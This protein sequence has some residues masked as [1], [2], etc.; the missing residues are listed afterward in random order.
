M[1]VLLEGRS[2]RPF[3]SSEEYLI[4]MKE[5]LAEW[6]NA[7]YPELRINLDN[8]MDRLDTGV[9]LCKHA[10]NVRKYAG[11][12]VARRQ[13]RKMPM[14]RSITS[15][16]LPMSQVGDMPYLPNA[17]AGTFF[18]RDNVSNFIDWCRNS[19]GIIECLLFETE[20]LIMRKNERHVILCLLEVARRGAKFGMLAPLLVQMERQIDR[21]IAA[22]NK[23]ANG[24]DNEESDDEYEEEPCL[25]YGPQPQIVT[26][27]L[28]TLHELV[29]DIVEECTCPTQ[30]PMIHVAEGKY[31]IGDTKV[32][33]YV[34]VLRSHVM[35][36][37]GGGW[38]T[39]SHYLEKHDP[40]RCRNSHR[41][42]VSAKLIQKA[43]GSFDLGN[44]Q[45]HYERS[46]PPR[47]RR[48]SASS[49]GS[50]QNLQSAQLHAP[51]RSISSNRS[52]SPTPHR[53]TAGSKQ[54]QQHQLQSS[55]ELKK[56]SR[57][58]TPH[59]KLLASPNQHQADLAKQ[60]SRSPTPRANL[61]SRSPTPRKNI[62]SFKRNANEEARSPPYHGKLQENGRES[63][64]KVPG[65]FTKRYIVEG[66]VARRAV[67]KD[68]T[69]KYEPSIYNYKC[70]EDSSGSRSPTPSKEEQPPIETF[71]KDTT[72]NTQKSPHG[73]GEH[74]DNCSEVSDEGYRSLGALQSST[75]N[76]NSASTQSSPT[77]ADCQKQP[78]KTES[79]EK[80][81]V[82]TDSI[83]TGLRK[84]IRKDRLASP[85]RVSS[86]SRSVASSSTGDRTPR[87]G[88]VVRENSNLSKTSSGSKTPKDSNSSPEGSPLNRGG[89]IRKGNGS[90][91]TVRKSTPTGS[92]SKALSPTPIPNS[93]KTSVGGSA[94]WNGRQTRRRASIQT[95]TFL[96]PRSTPA[97]CTSTPSF[98][99]KSPGRQS[100]QSRPNMNGIQYDRNGR[101]I[102][103]SATGTASLQSSPT[104]VTNPLLDQILQKLGDLKD[105]RQMVQKLQGLLR[106][107][108]A[109]STDGAA[110]MDFAKMWVDSN[111]TMTVPQ[112]VQVSVTPRKDPKPQE[113]CSRIPVP[114]TV[115]YKRP[116][117]VA[118]D[119]V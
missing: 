50:V 48:S 118:S 33:I 82:E 89:S 23:A 101:R 27:D 46:S 12:Y 19:L 60:R 13:A 84:V 69:P 5:D 44:A 30:F 68:D 113:G 66:G 98:S 91:G 114:R 11:D 75:A 100:L 112:D 22:E 67:E 90:Y 70:S 86:P 80:S 110:N 64:L 108:Q 76:G 20:D 105:E 71:G 59:R 16:A 56:R 53:P 58:P 97:T 104:K 34:R 4:A 8:F 115:S 43:G 93:T 9:A 31:R 24:A 102:R 109:S 17:K 63:G 106:D 32:T 54:Q 49:V 94:T 35:V 38:D 72:A 116:M 92:L 45:V 74:S 40:C 6:L 83:E 77:V 36:R 28:K 21:E 79:E 51:P 65:E 39:L 78:P 119:S 14:T 111:G 3:K 55:D 41:S 99:R 57:S 37:V 10:N 103:G 107:Y 81:G 1:S 2:Y 26:N 7:L 47:T 25:I 95:D 18:A 85:L 61:R 42:M 15:L 73:D 29:R 88:S 96:D 117:S 52:R 87:A 62:D